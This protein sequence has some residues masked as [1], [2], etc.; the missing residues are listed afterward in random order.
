MD[1][2]GYNNEDNKW[3]EE[4]IARLSPPPGWKPDA[5]VAF[6][7]LMQGK[8]ASK[9]RALRLSLAGVTLVAIAGIVALLPWQLLWTGRTA[10]KAAS[11]AVFTGP[12]DPA[13]ESI[14]VTEPAQ[15]TTIPQTDPKDPF[16]A[17]NTQSPVPAAA[18]ATST[19]PLEVA[20]PSQEP[21]PK[22]KKN[23]TLHASAAEQ[24]GRNILQSPGASAK[25]IEPASAAL[26]APQ[27]GVTEPIVVYRVTP[28]YTA[29]ARVARVT[30]DVELVA[31]VREDGSVKFERITKSLGYGLDEAS[32]AAVEQWKF[33]PGKKD[34]KPVAV[35][36]KLVFHFGLK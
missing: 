33:I 7:R 17:Q 6:E 15:Q 29:E 3:V 11:Q 16:V 36:T 28:E 27:E 34:G 20:I 31:T 21:L 26:Q 4:R 1:N 22:Q 25:P 9:S 5:D 24:A 2:P 23:H 32:A 19:A 14:R 13:A 18:S 8:P 35:M 30:G 10:E 12:V